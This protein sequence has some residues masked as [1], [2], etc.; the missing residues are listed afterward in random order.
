MSVPD[1]D[2][3]YRSGDL[4]WDTGRP[5]DNLATLVG[6]ETI[7]LCTA[8]E[9]GC[10]TGTNVIWLAQQGF[11]VV[12]IDISPTAIEMARKK[13]ATTE[14]DCTLIALDIL[15]E[16]VSGGPFGFVFD[17]GCLHSLDSPEERARFAVAVAGHLEPDG[18]WLSILGNA[19]DPPR[20]IGPPRRSATEIVLAVESH[21]EILELRTTYFN[22]DRPEPPRAWRCLMSKR[23]G[24][25]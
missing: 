20:D 4:P 7:S 22:V 15:K 10:G 12:G 14:V 25:R 1:W 5:D 8:M 24:P 23:P 19:D 9:I 13:L 2:E 18:L 16:T 11:N 3:R 17:L 6:D 21:F